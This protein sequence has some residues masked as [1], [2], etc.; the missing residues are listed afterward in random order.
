MI[1]ASS[2]FEGKE[3]PLSAFASQELENSKQFILFLYSTNTGNTVA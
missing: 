1:I 3:Q 2:A